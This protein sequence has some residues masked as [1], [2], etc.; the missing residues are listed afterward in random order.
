MAKKKAAKK[1]AG[2]SRKP[3]GSVKDAAARRAI[4]PVDPLRRALGRALR[5]LGIT[6]VMLAK[7]EVKKQAVL[8]CIEATGHVGRSCAAAGVGRRTFYDWLET[9]AEFRAGY[10]KARQRGRDVILDAATERAVWGLERLKFSKDGVPCYD[11]RTGKVYVER[12]FSDHVLMGLLTAAFPERF[13]QR[14][15]VEHTGQVATGPVAPVP[16]LTILL[17]DPG[18]RVSANSPR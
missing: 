2:R 8:A 4:T 3:R 14:S 12:Q 5:E 11:P 9:D 1:K 18:G 15:K 13:A 7:P 10:E 17:R 6:P 16:R